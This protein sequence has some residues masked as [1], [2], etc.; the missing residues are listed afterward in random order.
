MMK[1]SAAA[2]K[3][4]TDSMIA[5]RF[6][7]I[8]HRKI[9]LQT[10]GLDVAGRNLEVMEAFV[11]FCL[12]LHKR[13]GWEHRSIFFWRRNCLYIKESQGFVR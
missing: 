2:E 7:E 8:N 6:P 12:L 9:R 4:L 10:G 3:T 5:L 11:R 13:Y 1:E